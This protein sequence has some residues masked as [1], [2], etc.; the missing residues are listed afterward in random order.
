ML[1]L[2]KNFVR[3]FL[4][5]QIERYGEVVFMAT[6]LSARRLRINGIVQGVGFRPF[7][8]QLAEHCNLKG[9]V[10]NTSSGVAIH[11]EGI[12]E[13]LSIFCRNITV[14]KPPLAQITDI[15]SQDTTPEGY[16]N[17]TISESRQQAFKNTLI[18][19]DAA[20][21]EDCLREVTDPTDRRFGYPFTNCTN[22]GPRY[23]IIDDIPYDRPNTSMK[24]FAMCE[25]CRAEYDDPAN[26]RFHA[27]PNACA[28][29]GP[30][31][32][33]YDKDGK[34]VKPVGVTDRDDPVATAGLLL[35]A[36]HIVAV[37]GLGGFHLAV[38]AQNN[39]AV[40]RLRQ[41][42][43]R[44][45]KPFALMSASLER[46]YRF[47]Y[48]DPAEEKL[49]TS[50][51]RPIVLLRKR[52]CDHIADGV[53][54]ENNYFGVMLPSTPLHY[55]LLGDTFAALVMTSGN[56]SEEPIAID[57]GDAFNRLAGIADYFL[58]H[59][60][61]IYLRSDDSIVRYAGGAERILRRSR[62]YVPV[63]VFLKENVPQILACGAMLKNTIC[64]TKGKNAFLS[65]HIGDLENLRTFDF[66]T[67][68]IEHMKHI[69]DITPE[70]IAYDMHPD[71][72]ST[73]YA[74]DQADTVMAIPVQH[75]HAHVAAC[76]AENRVDG[77]VIGLAFDG[78]GYGTDG[79]IWG[80]EA[81]IADEAS[82]E[83]AA[84]LAYVPMPGGEAAV[85]AP[86]RM[87]VSFLFDSMG[88]DFW[89]AD[90][91]LF[92]MIAKADIEV[93]V[94]M[95]VKRINSPLT[96]G[97][98]RFF[99][100][101]AAILGIHNHV[102]FEGQAAMAL[103][104][105]AYPDRV[106][107]EQDDIYPYQLPPDGELS[108]SSRPIISAIVQDMQN[109]ITTAQISTRFHGTLI[110]LFSALCDRIRLRTGLNRVALSGGV[111]QN[112]ILLEGM[113]RTL[114]ET[115]FEVYS[116]SRVPTNDGGISLGQAIIAAAK[117]RT[118]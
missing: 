98:G 7:I 29:C 89:D 106:F 66:F 116:H 77:K 9:I 114:T 61:E 25:P 101:V 105:M 12:P 73:R 118:L 92:K 55:L 32:A 27:Q 82:F 85:K 16:T 84:H 97:M 107:F 17:F 59:N 52:A 76:M 3:L 58:I 6:L 91:P 24:H 90:L 113:T 4:R 80:G 103:E 68:T 111:F 79:H 51:R 72:L 108:I 78:T 96:S 10:A 99:D 43:H 1:S 50:Y 75:H 49:L 8:R 40:A 35:K 69:L 95:M 15:A 62:G 112:V 100:G 45:E 109:G 13:E 34:A 110:H 36:G 22:C 37:K 60:R 39:G 86:W 56:L 93:V 14:R 28:A 71:Y 20:T 65:Q 117:S 48:I 21:C 54:P 23:T 5:L 70:M 102:C 67:S 26:R 19:P 30:H 104:N 31:V 38:D 33:L 88:D 83:R 115:G 94:R 46:I 74:H 2:V 41:R 81:L 87:G 64:L 42:K 47:A 44:E 18:S 57:N 53:S 11:I 63:P